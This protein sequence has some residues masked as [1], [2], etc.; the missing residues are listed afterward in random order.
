MDLFY[1]LAATRLPLR[2]IV[3]L[4]SE[5]VVLLYGT[6]AILLINGVSFRLATPMWGRWADKYSQ[7]GITPAQRRGPPTNIPLG[8]GLLL[9]ST[10]AAV[11]AAPVS[12]ILGGLAAVA[13][14][15]AAL[16]WI[17]PPAWALPTW[18][19][20]TTAEPIRG[21]QSWWRSNRL[22]WVVVCA[23]ALAA[24][25]VLLTVVHSS[26]LRVAALLLLS[27]GG[28]AAAARRARRSAG[29]THRDDG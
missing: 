25:V 18:M 2:L 11:H 26:V 9:A 13:I 3:E 15:V 4:V 17:H 21:D 8:V 12:G 10:A 19:R 23:V 22:I 29:T 6:G 7:G 24:V 5:L 27:A 20:A 14:A 16:F 1:R 28:S